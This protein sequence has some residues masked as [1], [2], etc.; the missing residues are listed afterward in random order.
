[1]LDILLCIMPR[2]EPNA[3]TAG[4]GVLKAHLLEEGFSAEVVDLN[5]DLYR[6]LEKLGT[7]QEH[8]LITKFILVI[9]PVIL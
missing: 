2:V 3:P 6:F 4:A 7:H 8:F 9:N 1:M 5:I